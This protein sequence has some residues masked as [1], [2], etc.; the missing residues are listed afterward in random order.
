ME[1]FKLD[2]VNNTLIITK[3]FEEKLQDFTSSEFAKFKEIKEAFPTI[4]V[5]RKT[6]NSPKK[7]YSNGKNTSCN[8]SKNMKYSNMEKFIAL[9]PNNDEYMAQYYTLR[10]M[11]SLLP[12][13]Y[14]LVRKWFVEQFPQY[15]TNPLFY[16]E[17]KVELALIE[18]KAAA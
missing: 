9:L 12:N 15:N 14:T 11:A 4:K 16:I 5:V 2:I 17:N 8:P 1:K 6:H 13:G 7:Y 10:E 3:A 18:E